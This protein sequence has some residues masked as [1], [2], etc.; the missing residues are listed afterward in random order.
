MLIA[1]LT[2]EIAANFEICLAL[3]NASGMTISSI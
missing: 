2:D 1:I 3:I